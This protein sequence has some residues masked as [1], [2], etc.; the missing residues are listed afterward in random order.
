VKLSERIKNC[1]MI[2]GIALFII[3]FSISGAF[4]VPAALNI[5]ITDVTPVSFSVVW[6]TDVPA[7]PYVEVYSDALMT[8]R[9]TD[10]LIITPMPA[11]SSAVAQ[12]A[13]NMGIMKVRVSGLA[14]SAKYYFRAVTKDSQNPASTGYS[15]VYEV[16][17][18]SKIIPY[19]N[20]Q[21]FSNDLAFFNVYVRP[22]DS[23]DKSGAGYLVIVETD[24]AAY[25]VTAFAGD[26][27]GAP[28]CIIDL[29]NLFNADG[30]NLD[31]AGNEK[32]IITVYRKW[33]LSP[34][35][36]YRKVAPDGNLVRVA[37]SVKGFFADINLDG[38][39]DE[40]DLNE[41][42]KQYRMM[43]DDS[44]YNP[45]FNFVT[46]SGE[47]VDVREFSKFSIEYGRINVE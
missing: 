37:E 44:A 15:P 43:P 26:G 16:A 31:L 8:S 6:T 17:M 39:I 19:R 47:K 28:G 41:M 27:T 32:M 2:F 46:D 20:E 4:A 13:K 25:P 9:I 29:N 33:T 21:V 30:E 18:A 24:G 5:R 40:T 36:H 23:G 12:A 38:K 42:K 35:T 11:A 7:D 22:S 45:D 10:G 14:A 3:L 1:G 34:L